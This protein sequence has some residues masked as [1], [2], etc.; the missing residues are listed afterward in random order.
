MP[1]GGD[2]AGDKAAQKSSDNRAGHIG[3][4]GAADAA[5][6]PFLI[7]VGEHHRDDTRYE[8]TLGETPEDER[9]QGGGGRRQGGG[10]G[11]KK[12]R[13]HDHFFAPTALGNH[14]D[15]GCGERGRKNSRAYGETYVQLGGM[16]CLAQERQQGL[17]AVDVK[18]RAHAGQ[19]GCD[20]RFV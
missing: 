18:K 10:N 13:W 1:V 11:Q 8:K 5:S 7:N 9:A 15:N 4:H 20:C 2:D 16:K 12:Q 17:S 3:R 6:G 19:H 14:S